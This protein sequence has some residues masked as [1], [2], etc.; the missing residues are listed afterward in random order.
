VR[1]VFGQNPFGGFGGPGGGG[2]PGRR[3]VP[4]DRRGP[5][6]GPGGAGGAGGAPGEGGP[7]F[8][9]ARLNPVAQII[10]LRDSLG[11]DSAQVARLEPVR[12]SLAARNQKLA[13][14]LRAQIQRLGSNPDPAVVFSQVIRPRL[15]ETRALLD[16]T[17]KEVRTILTPEQWAKVPADVKD[18]ARRFQGGPGGPGGGR[19]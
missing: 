14:S 3:A 10:D 9:G 1:Y 17:L 6:G 15:G 2:G 18:P 8:G 11:L 12:D 4:G 7:N 16:Q 19:P 13:E 5:G